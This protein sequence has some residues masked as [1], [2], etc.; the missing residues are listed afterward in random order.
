MNDDFAF[1]EEKVTDKSSGQN[2]V[3]IMMQKKEKKQ[4]GSESKDRSR[5]A[6]D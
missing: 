2:T 6:E 4:Y 5:E 1:F 3:E